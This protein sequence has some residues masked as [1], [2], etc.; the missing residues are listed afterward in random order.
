MKT[1][2]IINPCAGKKDL[3]DSISKTVRDAGKNADI[4]ITRSRGDA[5]DFVKAYCEKNGPARFIACG[6]DGTLSEVLCG[7]MECE[8]CEIGVIPSGTGNDFR[9]NFDKY[10]DFSDVNEQMTCTTVWCD[11]IKYTL[12]AG[13]HKI[14]GYCAN[15]INIGFDCNVASLTSRL[16]TKPFIRGSFAYFLSILINLAGKKGADLDIFLDGEKVHSGKLLLTSIANGC[17]CGGG[18]KSNPKACV[19]S[20]TMD[21]NIIKDVPRGKFISLLPGYMKGTLHDKRGIEN[22][23]LSKECRKISIVPRNGIT[24]VCIDGEIFSAERAEFEVVNKAFDFA[25]PLKRVPGAPPAEI[26]N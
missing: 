19:L 15:M 8:G 11:A 5:A 23:L 2:F 24:D 18:I 1:I 16:K 13:E 22:I 26:L 9:R 25:V 21:I 14:C 7:V 3:S 4:Y 20:G 12:T 6:G 10:L 17:F